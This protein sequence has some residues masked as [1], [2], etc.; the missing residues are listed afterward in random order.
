MALEE[1]GICGGRSE[2]PFSMSR[3]GISI[4]GGGSCT[5]SGITGVPMISPA[6]RGIVEKERSDL[7]IV[8][9]CQMDLLICFE[10]V[11]F[12]ESEAVDGNGGKAKV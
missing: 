5:W 8:E 11:G 6:N 2:E 10:G 12:E 3:L 7:V 4:D 1:R 9:I